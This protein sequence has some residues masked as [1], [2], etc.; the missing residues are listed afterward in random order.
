MW[1]YDREFRRHGDD[2]MGRS[3]RQRVMGR[4]ARLKEVPLCVRNGQIQT[5]G[6]RGI[7]TLDALVPS[8]SYGFHGALNANVATAA[9]VGCPNRPWVLDQG[10]G[11][12]LP[13]EGLRDWFGHPIVR[14]RKI[15]KLM[16]RSCNT[17]AARR[18][19]LDSAPDFWVRS[20][21]FS[22]META[23]RCPSVLFGN[24]IGEHSATAPAGVSIRHTQ[25]ARG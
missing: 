24:S 12:G 16:R 6:E 18:A 13:I 25:P 22:R 15:K 8:A 1:T 11:C 7:R 20:V 4:V 2:R 17:S 10:E 21:R 9:M 5:G 3:S 19:A 14:S 23:T